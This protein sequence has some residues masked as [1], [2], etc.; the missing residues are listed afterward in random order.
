MRECE[1]A[2][3]SERE[4]ACVCVC[5]CVCVYVCVCVC[6]RERAAVCTKE[7]VWVREVDVLMHDR[8][9]TLPHESAQASKFISHL[10]EYAD[11]NAKSLQLATQQSV[12]GQQSNDRLMNLFAWV[13]SCGCRILR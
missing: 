3:V 8:G 6:E 2:S 11:K 1:R 5:V 12:P 10:L 13:D 4:R 7:R 9:R